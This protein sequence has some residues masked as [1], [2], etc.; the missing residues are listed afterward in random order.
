MTLSNILNTSYNLTE[1]EYNLK[2]ENNMMGR[3]QNTKDALRRD[4]FGK[5]RNNK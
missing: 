4:G 1:I 3:D 2:L 5:S